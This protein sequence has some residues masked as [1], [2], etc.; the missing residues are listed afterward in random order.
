M[1]EAN[2][3]D[4][5]LFALGFGDDVDFDF[6]KKLALQNGGIARKIYTNADATLQLQ[7]HA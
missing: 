1:K 3:D 4:V 6:L 7:V 5:N 2:T